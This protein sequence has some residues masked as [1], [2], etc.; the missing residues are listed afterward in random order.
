MIDFFFNM[1]S[2]RVMNSYVITYNLLLV[3]KSKHRSFWTLKSL[4]FIWKYLSLLFLH[5]SLS[6]S[7]PLLNIWSAPQSLS[8]QLLCS[9]LFYLVTES[10]AA[11][12]WRQ[13]NNIGLY[14]ISIRCVQLKNDTS[15]FHST[16][17]WLLNLS[18]GEFCSLFPRHTFTHKHLSV[19]L[20]LNLSVYFPFEV[21]Y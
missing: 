20:V 9:L 12:P 4:L 16:S 15:N 5:K 18:Y 1:S 17:I 3:L 21:K 2:A 7:D 10:N 8:N 14:I 19:W 13:N 6:T 11:V